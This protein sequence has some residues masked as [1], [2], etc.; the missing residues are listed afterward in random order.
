MI[1]FP[2]AVPVLTI[3]FLS[4]FTISL[5]LAQLPILCVSISWGK[6]T[7]SI[8]VTEELV[9]Q[10]YTEALLTCLSSFHNHLW[11]NE[12][13]SMGTKRSLFKETKMY[14]H[15]FAEGSTHTVRANLVQ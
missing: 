1:F 11:K 2:S 13:V 9:E 5:L 6:H 8:R 4:L 3:L 15:M 10:G 12:Q 7:K 14:L